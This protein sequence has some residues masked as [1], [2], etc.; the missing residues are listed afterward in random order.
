[1]ALAL[2]SDTPET[3]GVRVEWRTGSADASDQLDLVATVD[4]DE[5][6]RAEIAWLNGEAIE[7]WSAENGLETTLGL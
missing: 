1:M 3:S 4:Y 7:I 6:G 5:D 2:V